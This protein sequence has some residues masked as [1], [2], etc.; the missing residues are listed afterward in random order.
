MPYI[1]NVL[2]DISDQDLPLALKLLASSGHFD[3]DGETSEAKNLIGFGQGLG[4]EDLPP[5]LGGIER[6]ALFDQPRD[7]FI[8]VYLQ[9][10]PR[11]CDLGSPACLVDGRSPTAIFME[12]DVAATPPGSTSRVPAS[13]RR[14]C[15]TSRSRRRARRSAI[16]PEA[17]RG[18]PGFPAH[19]VRR[20]GAVAERLLHA[21]HDRAEQRAPGHRHLGDFCELIGKDP[22]AAMMKLGNNVAGVL[23]AQH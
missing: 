7:L 5:T 8:V 19:A 2:G 17:L 1:G 3:G 4:G 9:P 16:V 6:S 13:S 21:A 20:D 12:T 18:R 10:L 22:A 15:C 14:S 11:R 23:G